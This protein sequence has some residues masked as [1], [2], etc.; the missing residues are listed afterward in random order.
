MTGEATETAKSP[1]KS[2][3]KSPGKQGTKRTYDD[4]SVDIQ[5]PAQLCVVLN[6]E[7]RFTKW[8]RMKVTML[9]ALGL[10][11]GEEPE[12][13]KP[14]CLADVAVDVGEHGYIVAKCAHPQKEGTEVCLVEKGRGKGFVLMPESGVKT[15]AGPRVLVTQ[16]EQ[17]YSRWPAMET[18]LALT[19]TPKFKAPKGGTGFLLGSAPHPKDADIT[20]CAVGFPSRKADDPDGQRVAFIRKSALKEMPNDIVEIVLPDERLTGWAKMAETVGVEETE[21]VKVLKGMLGIPKLERTHLKKPDVQVVGVELLPP[22]PG[23]SGRGQHVSG[24]VVM[25]K[26]ALKYI[27]S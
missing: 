17:Q 11:T 18:T 6:A 3:A 27:K 7:Q 20:V 8:D 10:L 26:K 15:M 24:Q 14:A 19:I 12:D 5:T 2:P 13:A 1:V 4:V 22:H 16:F 23:L 21:S 25:L 9:Q